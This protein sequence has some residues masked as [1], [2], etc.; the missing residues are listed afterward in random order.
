MTNTAKQLALWLIKRP[1][2]QVASGQACGFV[3]AADHPNTARQFASTQAGD[4]GADAWLDPTRSSVTVIGEA[5]LGA[6]QGI[7]L[8]DFWAG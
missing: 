8:C 7:V 2:D 5:T 3:I 6:E 1:E 4:E